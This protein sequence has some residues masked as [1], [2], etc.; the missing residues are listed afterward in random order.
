MEEDT[1]LY[2]FTTDSSSDPLYSASLQV[3]F[4]FAVSTTCTISTF[5]KEN[6]GS[7]ANIEKRTVLRL[8]K[9]KIRERIW[10]YGASILLM[11]LNSK[12]LQLC[13]L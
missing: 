2:R 3:F 12:L 13:L 8:G 11:L 9:K 6:L 10:T 4:T 5:V 7:K 1:N